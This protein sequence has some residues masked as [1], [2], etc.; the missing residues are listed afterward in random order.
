VKRAPP[1]VLVAIVAGAALTAFA[2]A[3]NAPP[4]LTSAG[5]LARSSGSGSASGTGSRGTCGVERWT[6]KTLQDRPALLRVKPTTVAYLISRPRPARLTSARLPFERHVF[7][8]TAS[9]VLVRAW[10]HGGLRLV[11]EAGRNRR[12]IAEVPSPLCDAH[13]TAVRRKQMSTAR[14]A[15]RVCVNAAVT[16]VAFFDFKHRQYGVA[17]NAIE[18]HP[19]IGFRCAE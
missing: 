10:A 8:V 15:V 14:A 12:M 16:G 11:L 6:V 18:L 9:V 13:A 5:S 3:D 19:V 1:A 4:V 17:P 2:S 7:R